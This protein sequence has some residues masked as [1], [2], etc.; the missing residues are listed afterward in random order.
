M[1]L[2]AQP[3]SATFIVTQLD[4]LAGHVALNINMEHEVPLP[5]T[6]SRLTCGQVAVLILMSI[7]LF[8]TAHCTGVTLCDHIKSYP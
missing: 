6:T 2:S 5:D 8:I 3:E 1:S 4:K 7:L